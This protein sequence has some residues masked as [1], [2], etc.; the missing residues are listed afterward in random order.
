MASP[1]NAT[2]L[3]T[4][5]DTAAIQ[6][7]INAACSTGGSVYFPPPPGGY[8]GLR[9][10]QV[11]STSTVLKIPCNSLHLIGGNVALSSSAIQP[12]GA[13]APQVA[14]YAIPGASPNAM[15]IFGLGAGYNCSGGV[16]PCTISNPGPYANTGTTFENL[17]ISGHNEA[18]A[19]WGASK[20]T[21]RNVNLGAATTSQTD[22]TPL[23]ISNSFWIFYYGG[24]LDTTGAVPSMLLTAETPTGLGDAQDV[25]LLDFEGTT[26]TS[27]KGIQF[28]Q[29]GTSSNPSGG[30]TFNNIVSENT[31]T[32][33]LTISNVSGTTIIVAELTFNQDSIADSDIRDPF[34][35]FSAASSG[36]ALYGVHMNQVLGSKGGS[37]I[38]VTGGGYIA[39]YQV[40][41][42]KFACNAQ[43]TDTNGNT[44]GNGQIQDNGG[45]LDFIDSTVGQISKIFYAQAGANTTSARFYKGGNQVAYMGLDAY[46]GLLGN[47]GSSFG[48]SAG[49]NQSVK[50]AWDVE[51]AKLLPPTAVAGFAAAGGSIANGTYYVWVSTASDSADCNVQS[52]AGLPSSA[53]LLS[54]KN[55]TINA[56]WTLPVSTVVTP[57]GYCVGISTQNINPPVGTANSF[58]SGP[59]TTSTSITSTNGTYQFL[60]YNT[61]AARHRFT[62]NSLNLTGGLNI[63]NDTGS[64]NAYV[65][66]PAPAISTVP[67]GYQTCFF[68]AHSNTAT[69]TLTVGTASAITIKKNG[70][71]LNLSSGDV[72][73]NSYFCVVY[74]GTQ[75]E[76]LGQLGNPPSGMTQML[77]GAYTNSTT[78]QTAVTG[79]SFLAAASTNYRY[80][81]DLVYESSANTAGLQIA[82]T[83]PSSPATV[84]YSIDSA[85]GTGTSL[86]AGATTGTSFGTTI[87]GSGSAPTATYMPSHIVLS[88]VNGSN[89]GTV[90]LTAA[91][92]GTGR[93]T[94]AAGSSCHQE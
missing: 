12:A 41:G 86:A 6:A 62:L 82:W 64:A 2:G 48:F 89:A 16:W 57:T 90:Q 53:V 61:L 46:G 33:F 71:S 67:I 68:A 9:Q 93:V 34:L 26:I 31:N 15:P 50:E 13:S 63:Y 39:N 40:N 43:V 85:I 59:T 87:G 20:T 10:P 55:G 49:L 47:D 44:A 58:V 74:D 66:T 76:A 92:H 88:L 78:G 5:D 22:N 37:A 30:W 72:L 83:G 25:A 21:F 81:C 38:E 94:V 65:I 56:S 45:G 60:A 27:G 35:L 29:R 28:I 11:P 8:Y 19:I 32:P 24:T 84:T 80:V 73:A 79:L 75:F 3:G 14:L 91:A 77:T 69:S 70:N 52:A 17:T 42:C 18:V 7:A 23:K 36:D 4:T 54:G 1:Y 51:L